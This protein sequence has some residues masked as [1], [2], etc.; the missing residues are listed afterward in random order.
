MVVV[1]V[2]VVTVVKVIVAD[3]AARQSDGL[4]ARVVSLGDLSFFQ[5]GPSQLP[6]AQ[7]S[8][9]LVTAE[10]LLRLLLLAVVRRVREPLPLLHEGLPDLPRVRTATR[11]VEKCTRRFALRIRARP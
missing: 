8:L 11:T 4:A 1:A 7:P 6:Q 3:R 5:H 2:T 9:V 10:Q